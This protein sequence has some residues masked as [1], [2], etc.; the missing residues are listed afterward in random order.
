MI[1]L[2]GNTMSKSYGESVIFSDISFNL[3]ERQK[4]ALVGRNGVGKTTLFK[5]I[6]FPE[7]LDMGSITY[8]KNIK[9]GYLEQ[10]NEKSD[11]TLMEYLL[12]SYGDIIDLRNNL[13]RLEY[14][15]SQTSIESLN[16]QK[17]LADYAE[18]TYH[19]E[20]LNGFSIESQIKGISNGLGF[21][22]D[23]LDRLISTFSGGEKSRLSLL[24]LLARNPDVLILD[25]PTN[26]LDIFS[27]EWLENYLK[28]YDGA[29]FIISHDRSFLN[30]IVTGIYELDDKSLK[31][32]HGDY[33]FYEKAKL[34]ELKIHHKAYEKQKKEI[35]KTEAFILKYKA[36]TR[37]KQARGREKKLEKIVR[38]E[39]IPQKKVINLK[40]SE[41][42][43][44]GNLV[45]SVSNLTHYWGE[46]KILNEVTFDIFKSDR[47]GLIGKNG[48]GKSTLVNLCLGNIQSIHNNVKIGSR[49]NIGY[50]EQ[51]HTILNL[52]RT[53]YE[54]ILYHFDLKKEE[55][56]S[57]LADFMF[58]QSD[59][60]KK[61]SILSGGE[62]TRLALLIILLKKPNFLILDE[63]TNHLDLDSQKIIM[64]YLQS[65]S[66]TLLIISHDRYFLDGVVDKIFLLENKQLKKFSGNYTY[67]KEKSLEIQRI[68]VEKEKNVVLREK[69]VKEKSSMSKSKLREFIDEYEKEIVEK[70][71]LLKD[72]KEESCNIA[73]SDYQSFEL[74]GKDIGQLE[75]SL[76]SLYS[77]WEELNQDLEDLL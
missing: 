68:E 8:A 43:E 44:S 29:I 74:I 48:S 4:I 28:S 45:L 17:L 42:K 52:E 31:Y 37:S 46:E 18:I 23:D 63:P 27:I 32:Y 57:I 9:I 5:G 49:V 55:I 40:A 1:V 16:Y 36:G 39:K 69:K 34:E 14:E 10:F 24:K 54:E 20:S 2:Q 19:Y 59:L 67:Y 22:K 38:L 50:F 51:N 77:K 15:I 75:E 33:N 76:E 71:K 25:E 72:L 60:D 53:V 64:D 66:G 58:Y 13:T 12:E 61:I 65:Y 21:K 30:N 56:Y 41:I 11:V 26:H 73:P 35:E 3:H 70:E 6:M 7:T 62:K 47:I